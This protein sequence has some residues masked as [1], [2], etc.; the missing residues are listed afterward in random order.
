MTEND[1]KKCDYEALKESM[2]DFVRKNKSLS[3]EWMRSDN[4]VGDLLVENL[5]LAHK[6]DIALETLKHISI[7]SDDKADMNLCK[8]TINK[9]K[10]I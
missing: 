8:S 2:R 4:K 5:E 1:M 9:I 7:Y 6:L 10:E 3:D